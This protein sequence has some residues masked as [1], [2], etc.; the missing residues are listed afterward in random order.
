[1]REQTNALDNVGFKWCAADEVRLRMHVDGTA[2]TSVVDLL[3][4]DAL[5]ARYTNGE[6]MLSK[7]AYLLDYLFDAV[8]EVC[9]DGGFSHR[10]GVGW[11]IAMGAAEWRALKCVATRAR[12]QNAEFCDTGLS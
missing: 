8:N 1:M 5:R 6:C 2:T 11:V 4:I 12:S 10:K 7:Q 9:V 3:T